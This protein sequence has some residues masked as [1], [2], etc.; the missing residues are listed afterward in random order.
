MGETPPSTVELICPGCGAYFRL[1]P[2]KGK[3]PKGP[4]PCPKCGTSIPVELA[5]TPENNDMGADE[6][7]GHDPSQDSDPVEERGDTSAP[8][9]K[10]PKSPPMSGIISRPRKSARTSSS[11]EEKRASASSKPTSS[12]TPASSH[13]LAN[14]E[15]EPE[16]SDKAPT[17]D[18]HRAALEA[19]LDEDKGPNST[20]LG[21]GLTKKGAQ[22]KTAA[23]DEKILE[24]VRSTSTKPTTE[25]PSVPSPQQKSPDERGSTTD[26]SHFMRSRTEEGENETGEMD[27]NAAAQDLREGARGISDRE[28][29]MQ[30]EKLSFDHEKGAGGNKTPGSPDWS[31]E[32]EPGPFDLRDILEAEKEQIGP[33]VSNEVTR[34]PALDQNNPV[35]DAESKSGPKPLPTDPFFDIPDA[36]EAGS[37]QEKTTV[38]EVGDKQQDSPNTSSRADVLGRLKKSLR[39]STIPSKDEQEEDPAEALAA[40]LERLER[41]DLGSLAIESSEQSSK[42]VARETTENTRATFEQED[43]PAVSAS[44]IFEESSVAQ[45][46]VASSS[47]PEEQRS[48]P[49]LPEADDAGSTPGGKPPLAAL[50]KRKLGKA[51]VDELRGKVEGASEAYDESLSEAS[52]SSAKNHSKSPGLDDILSGADE[53]D[54]ARVLDE[55]GDL[56]TWPKSPAA[57]TPSTTAQTTPRS[58]S[59]SGSKP[60]ANTKLGGFAAIK[61]PP[62]EDGLE[63]Q[64]EQQPEAEAKPAPVLARLKA[65]PAPI[66]Q[67][68]PRLSLSQKRD[69]ARSLLRS[70]DTKKD[71][72]PAQETEE[73]S[74]VDDHQEQP[75]GLSWG[76]AALHRGDISSFGRK[77]RRQESHSGLFP[78]TGGLGQESSVGMASERRGSGYIRLPTSEILDVLGAGQYRLMVEDIVYEPVDE[79]GLT[80]LVKRGVL[81]GAELIAEQGGEWIPIVEHPVFKR[82]RKKMALEAHA[83]LAQYQRAADSSQEMTSVAMPVTEGSIE[84][85]QDDSKVEDMSDALVSMANIE[86]P[87]ALPADAS[88]EV[89]AFGLDDLSSEEEEEA[90]K[91]ASLLDLPNAPKIRDESEPLTDDAPREN[92]DV[93]VEESSSEL[94]E[95]L[96]DDASDPI[97][98]DDDQFPRFNSELD[99]GPSISFELPVYKD[100]PA[101]ED[102]EDLFEP[103]DIEETGSDDG[104]GQIEQPDHFEEPVAPAVQIQTP[105]IEDDADIEDPFA[106]TPGRRLPIGGILL[107]LLLVGLGIGASVLAVSPDLRASV[108]GPLGI[109]ET[110]DGPKEPS[111]TTPEAPKQDPGKAVAAASAKLFEA[112]T[113]FDFSDQTTLLGLAAEAKGEQALSI[114]RAAWTPQADSAATVAYANALAAAENWGELRQVVGAIAPGS[115][116]DIDALRTKAI[117]ND[118]AMRG[119]VHEPIKEGL[120]GDS[121]KVLPGRQVAF[122]L[123]NEADENTWVFLPSQ[124]RYDRSEYARDVIS[125]RLCQLITCN[126]LI[127]ETVPARIDEETFNTLL[128][129][130]QGS[131][132]ASPSERYSR[133]NWK[134]DGEGDEKTR[135]VEGVLRRWVEP[136]PAF[137]MNY[138]KTWRGWVDASLDAAQLDEPLEKSI[139]GV[140]GENEELYNQLIAQKG[141][142]STREF[143][144][145]VSSMIVLDFLLNNRD[146]FRERPTYNGVDNQIVDGRIV[147]YDHTAALDA[148][149][150][151]RVRGRMSWVT[152]LSKSQAESI[153][154]LDEEKANAI[155]FPEDANF[156]SS[157]QRA[158]WSR[159]AKLLGEIEEREKR[160]GKEEALGFE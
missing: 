95:D 38:H 158:F 19:L 60:R 59:D 92:E 14:K 5:S 102:S 81:M 155:L 12:S 126:I 67:P 57:A 64:A 33:Q 3:L 54:L 18:K 149:L 46:S 123:S 26:T 122:A 150:S 77:R 103:S 118:P 129:R 27:P 71:T 138:T 44:D 42:T 63:D 93:A 4:I 70:L 74:S 62:H 36:D 120:H 114:Y 127:P 84:S 7:Q 87:P 72:T 134:S 111:N 154:A 75:S 30:L 128:S 83:L 141:K 135:Y 136:G 143:G 52:E 147:S 11:E 132:A 130:G 160:Y 107:V 109:N 133:L 66:E 34:N 145:Q 115:N 151:S 146:R 29:P 65:A 113:A 49:S 116:A 1:K 22:E 131:G 79:V 94:S 105:P 41:G 98:D 89:G 28:T 32:N 137:D 21:F 10:K 25:N 156:S 91:P 56:S 142:L 16:V 106:P 78:I 144:R 73:V 61:I 108:L 76:D 139:E 104:L 23:I 15:E 97:G 24:Q 55:A 37:A 82:L 68:K 90:A 40:R 2:K 48:E 9:A 99:D 96:E 124:S 112:T 157:D 101:D 47:S 31:Q 43:S 159:H 35:G 58:A 80:E 8:A 119:F 110:I 51:G 121:M 140:K 152:R 45:D 86:L 85:Q 153:R 148:R 13:A 50:L 6:T 125:W 88:G 117:D 17:V 53:D 100:P 69:K 39:S 20:F